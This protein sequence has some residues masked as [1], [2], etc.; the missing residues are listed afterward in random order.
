MAAPIFSVPLLLHLSSR[1]KLNHL[2]NLSWL[3]LRLPAAAFNLRRCISSPTPLAVERLPRQPHSQSHWHVLDICVQT[4]DTVGFVFPQI[5]SV[6]NEAPQKLH[7]AHLP[8]V[9]AQLPVTFVRVGQVAGSPPLFV[10]SPPSTDSSVWAAIGCA[11]SSTVHFV[12]E[13]TETNLPGFLRHNL[14][15][16]KLLL[17][18]EQSRPRALCFSTFNEASF[19]LKM[20]F[21]FE[22]RD[23]R[24][25]SVAC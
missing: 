6:P 12:P 18:F 15:L 13:L 2:G 17:D 10:G 5:S 8:P 25:A 21:L 22:V 20:I 4:H 7:V 14:P 24:W 9:S 19:H 16:G 23:I 3:G 1:Y 11:G